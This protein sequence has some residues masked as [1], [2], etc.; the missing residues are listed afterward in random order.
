[1]PQ[2]RVVLI[3]TESQHAATQ[4]CVKSDRLSHNMPQPRFES[5]QTESQHT[6]SQVCVKSD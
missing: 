6:V 1:M 3:R 4:V 5:S 2:P